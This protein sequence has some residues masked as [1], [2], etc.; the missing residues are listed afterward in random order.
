MSLQ[1]ELTFYTDETMVQTAMVGLV[2]E[3][4]MSLGIRGDPGISPYEEW[5]LQGNTGSYDDFLTAIAQ[6]SSSAT[7]TENLW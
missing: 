6:L 7:W 5:Q 1:T 3:T 4:E 2:I